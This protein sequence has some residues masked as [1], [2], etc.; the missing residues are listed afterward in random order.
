MKIFLRCENS[1]ENGN[2]YL[3]GAVFRTLRNLYFTNLNE[4]LKKIVEEKGD[5]ILSLDSDFNQDI[6]NKQIEDLIAQGVDALF[7]IPVNPMKVVPALESAKEAG[8]PIFI[9]DTPIYDENLPTSTIASNN[10]NMGVL[11]AQD[12]MKRKEKAKI[13]ILHYPFFSTSTIARVEGFMN[14]I[15]DLPEYEIVSYKTDEENYENIKATVREIVRKHPEINV[16]VPTGDIT[17]M[18]AISTLKEM[19]KDQDIFVYGIDG[20]P[21]IKKLMKEGQ[22]EVSTAQAPIEMGMTAA[23]TAYTYLEGNPIEKYITIPVV[24]LTDENLDDYGVAT[25]K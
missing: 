8:I 1:R 11:I 16:I 3:F 23:E 14:T 15:K 10:Y 5:Q 25:Y 4:G 12:L 18:A 20:S 19:K 21:E 17:A 6:Q 22:I 24:L 13:A 2:S 7:V 9:V